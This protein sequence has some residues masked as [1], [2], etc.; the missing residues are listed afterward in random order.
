[1]YKRHQNTTFPEH[2]LKFQFGKM[3]RLCGAKHICKTKR[4]KRQMIGQLFELQI[5]RRK[6]TGRCGAKHI[7]KSKC[8]KHHMLGPRFELQMSKNRTPLWREAHL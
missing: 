7:C 8:T 6:I 5:R 2:V 4:T 3:A 1:M